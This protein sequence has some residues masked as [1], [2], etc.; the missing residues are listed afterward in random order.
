MAADGSADMVYFH[1]AVQFGKLAFNEGGH[2]LSVL[3]TGRIGYVT[4]SIVIQPALRMLLHALHDLLNDLAFAPNL[5]AG[6]QSA[7]IVHV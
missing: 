5:F 2:R 6:N 3:V 7:E 4:F 1:G